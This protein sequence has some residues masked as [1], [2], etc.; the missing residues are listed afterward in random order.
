L[1]DVAVVRPPEDAPGPIVLGTDFGPVSGAAERAAIHAAAQTGSELVIV[2]A[3]DAG[4]LRLPGGRWRTRVDQARTERERDAKQ[5]VALARQSGVHARVLIWTGDP[6]T[7][8]VDAARAEG[9]TRIVIGSHGRGPIGRAIAGSVSRTVSEMAS[10]PVAVVT[11]DGSERSRA[12]MPHGLLGGAV[13]PISG[14][15]NPVRISVEKD[16]ERSERTRSGGT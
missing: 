15:T 1:A 5:L 14:R 2:H 7:C 8:V 11:A 16:L 9:A 12:G 10:C 13:G 4:R 3:I 6:A